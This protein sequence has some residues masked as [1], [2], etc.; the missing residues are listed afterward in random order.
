MMLTSPEDGSLKPKLVVYIMENKIQ[1][2]YSML[3]F[4]I[5][6]TSLFLH[7]QL[8]NKNSKYDIKF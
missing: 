5:Q 2:Q 4:L 1:E 3:Y 7:I 8:Q 6:K